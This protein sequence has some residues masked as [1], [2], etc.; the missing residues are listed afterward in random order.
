MAD[1]VAGKE[2]QRIQQR[3]IHGSVGSVVTLVEALAMVTVEAWARA[4]W[5][6]R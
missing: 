6:W 4:W 1:N 2:Q 3:T 5:W